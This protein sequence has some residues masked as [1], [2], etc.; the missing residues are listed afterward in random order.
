MQR[1]PAALTWHLSTMPVQSPWLLPWAFLPRPEVLR[2][3]P[4]GGLLPIHTA[5]GTSAQH[6]LWSG[7]MGPHRPCGPVLLPK[8]PQEDPTTAQW[9][10]LSSAKLCVV[11]QA[12][13]TGEV[14]RSSQRRSR[15]IGGTQAAHTPLPSACARC[16]FRAGKLL[17]LAC[18]AEARGCRAAEGQGVGV[19]VLRIMPKVNN[20]HCTFPITGWCAVVAYAR[21]HGVPPY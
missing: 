21:M 20:I 8:S 18:R 19:G 12:Q 15:R 1:S 9:F 5:T 16:P 6:L 13:N 2:H 3:S 11:L 4:S 7:C 14:A 17:V 10:E